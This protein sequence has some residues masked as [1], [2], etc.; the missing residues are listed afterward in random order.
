MKKILC[1][2]LTA[3][4]LLCSCATEKQQ[5]EV[6][7]TLAFQIEDDYTIKF[8]LVAKENN[9]FEVV[10]TKDADFSYFVWKDSY[11]GTETEF[12]CDL[13]IIAPDIAYAMVNDTERIDSTTFHG[14]IAQGVHDVFLIKSFEGTI[15]IK[16]FIREEHQNSDYIL[17]ANTYDI[18]DY[19][20]TK[21]NAVD[22]REVD[23]VINAVH[24]NIK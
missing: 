11:N 5:I 18:K 1:I 23:S 7:Q 21:I 13:A 22:N 8:K 12:S 6:N 3:L 15:N 24:F 19:G 14:G 4:L 17:I 20:V 10:I 16:F 2:L 9:C